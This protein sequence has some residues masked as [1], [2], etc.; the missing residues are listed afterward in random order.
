MPDSGAGIEPLRNAEVLRLVDDPLAGRA[1][2]SPP[3]PGG[4]GAL[5]DP[6]A[7]GAAVRRVRG[8]GT[9]QFASGMAAHTPRP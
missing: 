2:S 6:A 5:A 3:W 7:N 1:G 9:A 8:L 4:R